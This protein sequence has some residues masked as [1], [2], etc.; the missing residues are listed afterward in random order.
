[1]LV[2]ALVA[3]MVGT[4]CAQTCADT[5]GDGT[6]TAYDCA[7][8]G[9]GTVNTDTS[10]TVDTA[11]C[12]DIACVETGNTAT[13]CLDTCAVAAA[14]VITAAAGG[15]TPCVGDYTC[16][17]GDGACPAAADVDCV[18]TG[19]TATDCLDTC[20]VA[21]ASVTTAQ[22]GTGQACAGDFTCTDGD[23]N[24]VAAA[25]ARADSDGSGSGYD[26]SGYGSDGPADGGS[27]DGGSTDCVETGNTAAD[28]LETCTVLVA[29]VVTP[30]AGSGAACAGNYTCVAGDGA[31]PPAPP[32]GPE[33]FVEAVVEVVT[34]V[35][36]QL[37]QCTPC[38]R[39]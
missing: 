32:P 19:N 36:T 38:T 15:G 3:G 27:T 31:C 26:G 28:C 2:V 30:T 24:C 4:A 25:G 22:S 7:A 23:G 37:K 34:Q 17:A 11:T 9:G 5:V 18:E 21:A 10:G 14:S 35:T 20:A 1:M 39:L 8:N 33:P 6:N 13:D 29:T 16:L 12:C